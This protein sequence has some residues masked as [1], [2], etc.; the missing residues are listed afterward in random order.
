VSMDDELLSVV[1]VRQFFFCRQIPYLN[2]VLHVV[3]PETESMVYSRERHEL[4]KAQYLPRDLRPRRVLTGVDLRSERL[5]LVGRL[6]ALVETVF[7]ELVPCELKHSALSRGRPLLKDIAQLAAYAML[8]EDV[9]R[10]V[11]KRGVL[12]Y[13]EDGGKAVV[14]IQQSHRD[15]VRMAVRRI[16]GMVASEEPPAERNLGACQGC[17]YR[18]ICYT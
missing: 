5:G 16:R 13:A 8:V 1:F 4:F 3:E 15:L 17:W 11:V 9:F 7:G 12:Y 14:R 18:R 6:D 10:A 2:L